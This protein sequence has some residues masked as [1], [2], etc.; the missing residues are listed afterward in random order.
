MM[1]LQA[2]SSLFSVAKSRWMT[3]AKRWI[4][5]ITPWKLRNEYHLKVDFLEDDS[6]PRWWFQICFIFT[7]IWGRF[8][9]WLI[10]FKW[11]ET[12]NQCPFKIVPFSGIQGTF[13]HLPAALGMAAIFS[14]AICQVEQGLKDR[15]LFQGVLR[16]HMNTCMHGSVLCAGTVPWIRCLGKRVGRKIF[17]NNSNQSVLIWSSVIWTCRPSF[18]DFEVFF[19]IKHCFIGWKKLKLNLSQLLAKGSQNFQKK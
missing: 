14:D 15:R 1:S 9:I 12:T 7:P 13:V 17:R 8:P 5:S 19:G 16:M 6:C 11:V 4:Y 10:F 2:Y 18:C 3:L